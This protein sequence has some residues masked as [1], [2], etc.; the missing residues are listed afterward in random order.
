MN[1][2]QGVCTPALEEDSTWSWEK[3]NSQETGSGEKK[4]YAAAGTLRKVSSQELGDGKDIVNRRTAYI[5]YPP[6]YSL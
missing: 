3:E 2:D 5:K 1:G 6:V 4:I